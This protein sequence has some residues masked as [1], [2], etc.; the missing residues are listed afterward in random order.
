MYLKKLKLGNEA[1]CICEACNGTGLY[2]G[3]T[4]RNGL[5]VICNACNGKGYYT[6]E[7]NESRQL[8]QDEKNGVVYKVNDG[9]ITDRIRLFDKLQRRDDVKYVMYGTGRVLSPEYL[10]EHGANEINVISYNNFLKGE[11]PIPAMQYTC[12]AELAQSYEDSSFDDSI[13]MKFCGFNSLFSDCKN[14]GSEEC[15]NKFYGNAKTI[16]EKQKRLKNMK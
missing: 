12:P 5:A 13:C 16:K 9:I 14:Y 8:V 6:L 3:F 11:F 7:L 10:F 2:V 4:E 15:W 1:K